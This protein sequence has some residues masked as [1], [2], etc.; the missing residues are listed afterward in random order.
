MI[1]YNYDHDQYVRDEMTYGNLPMPFPVRAVSRPTMTVVADGMSA[2]TLMQD[3]VGI[4]GRAH[5]TAAMLA[6]ARAKVAADEAMKI[7]RERPSV[8]RVTLL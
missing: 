8:Q 7:V 4:H 5:R 6:E 1:E 2:Q 3:A